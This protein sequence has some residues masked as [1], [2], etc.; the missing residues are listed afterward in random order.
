M[1][2]PILEPRLAAVPDAID[3]QVVELRAGDAPEPVNSEVFSVDIF[4]RGD[5][6]VIRTGRVPTGLQH[7]GNGVVPRIEICKRIVSSRVGERRIRD[8]PGDP[9]SPVLKAGL[10]HP[11][12]V[13]AI[14]VDKDR[15]TQGF[16]PYEYGIAEATKDRD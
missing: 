16:V 8:S 5:R 13:V 10:G 15:W 3:V 14:E 2:D 11:F 7:E 12:D 6:K 4:G 9:D 1:K